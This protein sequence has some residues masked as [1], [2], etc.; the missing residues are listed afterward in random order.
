MRYRYV[1]LGPLNSFKCPQ[2]FLKFKLVGMSEKQF[3][4]E[5]EKRGS[6]EEVHV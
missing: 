3:S 2:E 1:I 6:E 5:G 4:Y